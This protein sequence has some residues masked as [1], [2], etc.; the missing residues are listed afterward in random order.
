MWF[1]F[2]VNKINI[3]CT[4][5]LLLLCFWMIF[6]GFTVKSCQHS[7]DKQLTKT[8]EVRLLQYENLKALFSVSNDYGK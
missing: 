8:Y 1:L 3:L 4:L 6:K 5:Y 7:T 2:V